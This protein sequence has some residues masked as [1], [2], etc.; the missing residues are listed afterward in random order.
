M[1]KDEGCSQDIGGSL[2]QDKG[3]AVGWFL[4]VV[5]VSLRRRTR[6]F[7]SGPRFAL[8]P[9]PAAWEHLNRRSRPAAYSA[10]E[11]IS[12]KWRGLHALSRCRQLG[13]TIETP[14]TRTAGDPKS[15]QKNRAWKDTV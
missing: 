13:A 6:R 5:G 12:R 14:R 4:G 15:A 2:V 3:G 1:G 11:S 7:E 10:H 9:P 8:T